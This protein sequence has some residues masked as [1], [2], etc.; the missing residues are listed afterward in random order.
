MPSARHALKVVAHEA[1]RVVQTP[2]AFSN[3]PSLLSGLVREKL[4]SGP[5]TLT[6]EMRHG[7][8]ITIPN[9][10]GARVPVYEVFA[11]DAYRLRWFLGDLVERPLHALDIGG[12]V[13]TFSSWLANVHP[14]V[15]ID[16]YEPSPANVPYLRDNLRQNGLLDRVTV[17]EAALASTAGTALLDFQGAGS[18]LNGLVRG[19]DGVATGTAT[20]VVTETFDDFIAS[21]TTPVE[22]V[23][24]D[25]EGGEYDIVYGSSKDSWSTVQRLVLE[26]HE[27]E[28][29]RWTE[30]RDWFAAAGLQVIRD[31]PEHP[32]L[33]TAWLSR[34]PN[35]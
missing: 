5:D 4:G 35:P 31:E 13:G 15:V 6:F 18:G 17:H 30:L 7:Q 29:Q 9:R 25:C 2:K 11:E 23:K 10:P 33:G 22:L 24:M 14:T 34:T 16:C 1:K 8:R 26:Y 27:V 21:A 12:H 19:E 3:W 32:E 28:G 20:E